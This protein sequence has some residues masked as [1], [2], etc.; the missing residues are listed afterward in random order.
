MLPTP[1]TASASRLCV[2]RKTL[3]DG[4]QARSCSAPSITHEMLR[5]DAPCAMALMLMFWRP[6]D[7]EHLPRDAG[8]AFHA[9]ADHRQIAWSSLTSIRIDC[10]WNSNWNS[11]RIASI[12]R[13]RVL[14]PDGKADRVFR[15]R[16]RD[17]HDVD[18]ARSERAEHPAG[19][20]RHADH[21]RPAQRQQRQIADRGDPLGQLPVGSAF[22]RNQRARRRGV[23]RVLDEDRNALRDGGRDGGRVQHLGAEVRQLHRLFVG[24]RR[25]HER[26]RHHPWVGAQHAV[27]V[28]PDLDDRC[29]ERRADDRGA[30]VRSVAADGRRLAVVGCADE[31]R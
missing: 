16:L 7:V 27:D 31:S 21:A 30:V 22:A 9:L 20:A 18:A 14:A 19:H 4:V 23:E 2:S 5:S 3:V 1:T 15:R 10:S 25:Q 13:L 29:A 12:A 28:G 24:H 17:Q 11:W 6:S 8:T 26:C